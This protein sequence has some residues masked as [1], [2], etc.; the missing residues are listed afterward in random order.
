MQTDGRGQLRTDSFSWSPKQKYDEF[1][2]KHAPASMKPRVSTLQMLAGLGKCYTNPEKTVDIPRFVAKPASKKLIVPK[3]QKAKAAV[4][5]VEIKEVEEQDQRV[6]LTDL[7]NFLKAK[8]TVGPSWPRNMKPPSDPVPSQDKAFVSSRGT[9]FV[10][11]G[12]VRCISG[13]VN[14]FFIE[15]YRLISLVVTICID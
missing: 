1:W 12:R 8:T 3:S 4:P 2:K 10:F 7:C 15:S 5:W 11:S 14:R 6:T 13:H 9:F